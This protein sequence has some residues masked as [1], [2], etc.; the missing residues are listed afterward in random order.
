MGMGHKAVLQVYL[1]KICS[2]EITVSEI[3]I[4]KAGFL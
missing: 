2:S 3:R 1:L 4:A